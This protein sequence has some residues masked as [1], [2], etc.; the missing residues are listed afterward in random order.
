MNSYYFRD[1]I[2]PEY[3][4]RRLKGELLI[5]EEKSINLDELLTKLNIAMTY[6]EISSGVLGACKSKGLKRLIVINPNINNVG[7]ER[8]TIAHELGHLILHHG[9]R[10]C[11]ERDFD[12]FLTKN[13]IEKQANTFASELLLP[14]FELRKVLSRNEITIDLIMSI[15]QKYNASLISTAIRLVSICDEPVALFYHKDGK[16]KWGIRSPECIYNIEK[17]SL[18]S[19][20]IVNKLNKTNQSGKG[21]VNIDYW[22]D[23]NNDDTKCFEETMYFSNLNSYLTIAKIEDYDY[24]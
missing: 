2:D 22:F 19:L 11:K 24:Q 20:S 6:K 16:I 7:R 21:Y 14:K 10:Y 13:D 23:T 4:A 3:M 12:L 9:I 17:H 8:F 18:N 5:N 1:N 15:S